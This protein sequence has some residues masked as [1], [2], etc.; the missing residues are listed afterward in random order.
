MEI[1][2]Q[3]ILSFPKIE[4]HYCRLRTKRQYLD[5]GLNITKMHEL[6]VEKLASEYPGKKHVPIHTYRHIFNTKFNLGFHI[7]KKDACRQCEKYQ[8]SD[9][10]AILQ[11][12]FDNHIKRKE[13]ARLE[14]LSDKERS[15]SDTTFKSYTFDLQKVLS[16]PTG[17]VSSLYYSRK[18]SSYNLTFFDQGMY[19]KKYS[20][21]SDGIKT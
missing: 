7:P 4:S 12:D 21:S 16:T 19:F 5:E 6:Y 20:N 10:K 9:D 14:K 1:V 13:L 11:Q 8:N 3:H 2:K 15:I 18:F 17:N